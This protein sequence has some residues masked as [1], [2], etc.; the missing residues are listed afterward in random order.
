[1][2]Q[3]LVSLLILVTRSCLHVDMLKIINK[4]HYMI[5]YTSVLPHFVSVALLGEHVEKF[6]LARIFHK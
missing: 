5:Q 4:Y 2:F 1:M 3:L 6:S